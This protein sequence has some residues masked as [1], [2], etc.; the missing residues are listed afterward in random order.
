[1]SAEDSENETDSNGDVTEGRVMK[2]KFP[3]YRSPM[4]NCHKKINMCI[5]VNLFF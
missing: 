4:V 2:V 5:I 1:M 3:L